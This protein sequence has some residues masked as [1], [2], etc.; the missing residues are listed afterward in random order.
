MKKVKIILATLILLVS[1]SMNAQTEHKDYFVGKWNVVAV[2]TPD[3]D[4]K[5]LVTLYRKEGKLTGTVYSKA[6][7]AKEIKK[8]EEKGNSLTVS[9]KHGWFTIDLYMNKKDDT[10]VI[11]SLTDK[12]KASGVRLN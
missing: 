10:H 1:F 7:G 3:G 11:G 6:D 12:Y 4:S 8:V 9:F 5:I 2:G